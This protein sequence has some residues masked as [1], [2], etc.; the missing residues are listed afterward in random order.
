[1]LKT[2]INYKT[3]KYFPNYNFCGAKRFEYESPGFCCAKGAIKLISHPIPVELKNLY[4]K[5]NEKSKFFQ[6]YI[7]TY[8]NMFAFT[9]LGVNYDKDLAKRNK[10]IYTFRGHLVQK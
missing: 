3:L 1:M 4:L 6:T 7:R 9:S 2:S 10:G 8:N 5:N